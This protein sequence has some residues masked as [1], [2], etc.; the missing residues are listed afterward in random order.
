MADELTYEELKL[1]ERARDAFLSGKSVEYI[2]KHCPV[3]LNTNTSNGIGSLHATDY[4]IAGV[5]AGMRVLIGGQYGSGKS[6]AAYDIFN[7]YFGGSKLKNGEGVRID[8]NPDTNIMAP[9]NSIYT[10]YTGEE[11]A[12]IVT[13]KVELSKNV[14]ALFHWVDEINRTPTPKQNQF[15]APLNGQVSHEGREAHIGREGYSA[16]IA[17]ANLGNGLYQGTFDFDPALK[18]RFGVVIDTNYAL[19]EPTSEDRGLVALLREADPG[20]KAAPIRNISQQI[21]KAN[22]T[23]QQNSLHPYLE[24]QAVLWYLQEGLKTCLK[25]KDST[26]VKEGEFWFNE[27]RE[28]PYNPETSR[29]LCSFSGAP[30]Q[31]TLEATRKYAAA[32]S[33]LNT[34][35]SPDKPLNSV[36]LTFKA[37][38]LT[39]AYQPFINPDVTQNYK[40]HFGKLM[41]E[42]CALLKEDFRTKEDALCNSLETAQRG[43]TRY[44]VRNKVSP[45]EIMP[46]ELSPEQEKMKKELEEKYDFIN[47]FTEDRTIDLRWVDSRAE[48]LRKI[49]KTRR[50]AP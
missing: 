44:F 29:A 15:Y 8:V 40:G 49:S 11:K 36:D 41:K 1:G 4:I 3:Y 28:C 26:R 19:F 50:L 5:L 38:E 14:E 25:K 17:T 12:G 21:L 30:V 45:S 42:F 13:P 6:Q 9:V 34:L 16:V 27:C 20:L 46:L 7:Y 2:G 35:K 37:F 33:Y 48:L 24:E 32:L 23:I 47:L 18:N 22:K 43:N 31:R 39:A 10:C